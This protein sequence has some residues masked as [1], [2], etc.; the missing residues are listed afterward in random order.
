LV[1]KTSLGR[2]INLQ[3]RSEALNVWNWHS[4]TASGALSS[5]G[6]FATDL[7]SPEFGRWN[8]SVTDPR[9]IQLAA[10]LEF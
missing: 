10:R 5:G 4:F 3:L 1:K 6:A 7:A 9:V 8:G 2:G